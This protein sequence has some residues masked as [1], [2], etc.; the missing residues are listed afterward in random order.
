M[1]MAHSCWHGDDCCP[2]YGPD[3]M[4]QYRAQM[5]MLCSHVVRSLG[6][7]TL[8][9]WMTALPVAKRSRGGFLTRE[10]VLR[11]CGLMVQVVVWPD[12]ARG[13]VA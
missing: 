1:V 3:L 10:V 7:P 13:V 5:S 12:G 6:P 9:L 4:P 11:S 8:F 2:R